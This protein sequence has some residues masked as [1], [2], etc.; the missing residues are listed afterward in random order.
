MNVNIKQIL[1]LFFY[2]EIIKGFSIEGYLNDINIYKNELCSYNGIPT[3]NTQTNKVICECYSKYTNEPDEKNRRYINGNLVQCSYERK[4]QF[5]VT[6]IALCFPFGFDYLYLDRYLLFSFI[7]FMSLFGFSFNTV[8]FYVNHKNNMKT[9]E[10]RI[11]QK[12][13]ISNIDPKN[14]DPNKTHIKQ[15]Y[16]LA[17]ILLCI[18]LL[19]FIL[20]VTGHLFGYIR[21][22]YN[23][24][25][26]FDLLYMFEKPD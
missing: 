7:L 20:D 23:I 10:A 25:V 14:N 13:K 18:H 11:Q 15:F 6:F 19:Y 1:F 17:K 2:F 8:V 5:L 26:E 3:V 24:Q 21:D 12:M 9:K 22:R 4:S 16:I